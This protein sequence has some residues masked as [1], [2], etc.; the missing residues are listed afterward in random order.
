VPAAQVAMVATAV[1]AMAAVGITSMG[2]TVIRVA[3]AVAA[4]QVVINS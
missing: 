1:M 3:L 4:V 2:T